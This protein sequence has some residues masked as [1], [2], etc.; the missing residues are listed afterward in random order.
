MSTRKAEY[1]T[2]DELLDEV[3]SDRGALLLPQPQV[4]QPPQFDLELPRSA[5]PTT[6]STTCSTRTAHHEPVRA[7]PVRRR[8][9]PARPSPRPT[10]AALELAEEFELIQ[11]L[12]ATAEVVNAAARELAKAAPRGV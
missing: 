7:G 9:L 12:A 4:R 11:Q 8:R 5:R 1:V 10:V 6:R 3:G 2:L